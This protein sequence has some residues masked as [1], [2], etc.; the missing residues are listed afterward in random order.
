[1]KLPDRPEWLI[2][3]VISAGIS[4]LTMTL[5]FTLFRNQERNVFEAATIK[6]LELAGQGTAQ[7]MQTSKDLQALYEQDSARLAELLE[8]IDERDKSAIAYIHRQTILNLSNAESAVMGLVESLCFEDRD[9]CGAFQ[10]RM[11]L[12]QVLRRLD[13]IEAQM[14]QGGS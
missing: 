4:A 7:V 9:W 13:K 8:K 10:Q 1:M 5:F 6:T 2:V 12:K 14:P 11:M 3:C